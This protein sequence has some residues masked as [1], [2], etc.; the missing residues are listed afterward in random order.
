MHWKDCLAYQTTSWIFRKSV[1]E[2]F[3]HFLLLL[4][5]A[6]AVRDVPWGFCNHCAFFE[7][8]QLVMAHIKVGPW[9]S[10]VGSS[11]V[12]AIH[13]FKTGIIPGA[14]VA[15]KDLPINFSPF[16]HFNRLLPSKRVESFL[17][18]L[19]EIDRYGFFGANT[20]ADIIGQLWTDGRYRCFQYF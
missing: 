15:R 1:C 5:T 8:K 19:V 16:F 2:K 12:V 4:P 13:F 10:A 18:F 14:E 9:I 3:K 7:L 17:F 6:L 11:S 20:D